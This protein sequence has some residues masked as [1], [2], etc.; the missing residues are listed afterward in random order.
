MC[1]NKI[2]NSNQQSYFFQFTWC[3]ESLISSKY[4]I[5][6]ALNIIY[7]RSLSC[8]CKTPWTSTCTFS[9]F[10]TKWKKK[11]C[12]RYNWNASSLWFHCRNTRANIKWPYIHFFGFTLVSSWLQR[13]VYGH[14]VDIVCQ[15]PDTLDK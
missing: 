2:K 4:S 7:V 15:W 14:Y 11:N 6:T 1:L 3:T 5:T 8:N 10:Q 12:V 9:K 13:N